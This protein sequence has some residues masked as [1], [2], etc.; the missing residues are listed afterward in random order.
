MS[1]LNVL[2]LISL[3]V[4]TS[5]N[6][7]TAGKEHGVKIDTI[8]KRQLID[9]DSNFERFVEVFSTDPTFQQQR[10]LFPLKVKQYKTETDS[11]TV[12]YVQKSR[13]EHL[14]LSKKAVENERLNW[15]RMISVKGD[16]ATIQI[17]GVENGLAVEYEFRQI[18][19]KWFLVAVDDSST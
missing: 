16:K 11:D 19:G 18:N 8:A 2:M 13:L 1:R 6:I 10:T 3:F 14:D 12:F 7:D 17:Q 15:T 9:N 5:C 4:S